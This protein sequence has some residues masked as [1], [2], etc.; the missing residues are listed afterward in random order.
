MSDYELYGDYNEVDEP[1]K[2]SGVG[3]AIKLTAI[4]LCFAVVAFIAFR[5]FTFNY[6]PS[7]VTS[8]AYTDTLRDYYAATDGEIGALTQSLR[9]PYD[10]ESEG[11]FFCNNLI[12]IRGA[13]QLQ[14]C[15]RYN[16]SLPEK[17]GVSFNPEDI[18][19]TLRKSG[20]DE[21]ATG[22]AAGVTLDATL[23]VC[24]WDEFMMYRYAKLVFDGVDFDGAEWIRLDIEIDGVKRKTPFM[25][26][27][28]ED[29]A[30]FS[31]FTEYKLSSEEK[32]K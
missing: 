22:A 12:V 11:N 13:D 4:I 25:V 32:L 27:I 28:Y 24:E 1:P 5:L 14:V 26:C 6:Y 30:A 31:K 29:N 9:A 19:F 8:L 23:S 16:S 17:L 18:H 20:G 21:S 15:V 10:D 2:K 7:S 3:F